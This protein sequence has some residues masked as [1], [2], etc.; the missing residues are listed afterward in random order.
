MHRV[1]I[2]QRVGVDIGQRNA[3]GSQLV[4]AG[5]RL[6]GAVFGLDR[7]VCWASRKKVMVKVPSGLK[8]FFQERNWHLPFSARTPFHAPIKAGS[9]LG[10][11]TARP[12]SVAARTIRARE[13]FRFT[14]GMSFL[15]RSVRRVA[16]STRD[17]DALLR[18][19]NVVDML[20]AKL[21]VELELH[22]TP[23]PAG[24]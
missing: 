14:R 6:P 16:G 5:G 11:L 2:D 7:L 3:G 1:G 4:L 13:R 24:E 23:C 10:L 18:L 12:P 8:L 20:L 15:Q 21:T 17:R 22:D 9:V 19:G